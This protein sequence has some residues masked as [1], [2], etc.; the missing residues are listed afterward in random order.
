[1]AWVT[2]A[3][4]KGLGFAN[5]RIVND[6]LVV[7][8]M[9]GN[10][11]QQAGA[12]VGDVRGR[13]GDRG[14]QG[15]QGIQGVK[16]DRGFK[17]LGLANARVEGDL[18][19]IDVMDGDTKTGEL[20]AGNVRGPQGLKGDKGD[21]G[22]TGSASV[23]INDDQTGTE[24]TWSSSKIGATVQTAN[25]TLGQQISTLLAQKAALQHKHTAADLDSGVL[26]P[27]RIPAATASARGGLPIATEGEARAGTVNTKGMTPLTVK[28]AIDALV[29]APPVA[30]ETVAGVS[31]RATPAQVLAGADAARHVVPATLA[32]ALAPIRVDA[33]DAPML[34]HDFAGNTTPPNAVQSGQSLGYLPVGG[35]LSGAGAFTVADGMLDLATPPLGGGAQWGYVEADLGA[36]VQRQGVEFVWDTRNGTLTDPG[37]AALIPWNQPGIVAGGNGQT[38][39]LHLIFYS[40]GTVLAQYRP[41]TGAAMTTMATWS[42]PAMST[43]A[44]S[45]HRVEWWRSGDE[46]IIS[47]DGRDLILKNANLRAGP[48]ESFACW[49]PYPESGRARFRM[50]RIWAD[51][52]RDVPGARRFG[53]RRS[54]ALSKPV[55]RR[56]PGTG[57]EISGTANYVGLPN[58]TLQTSAGDSGRLLVTTRCFIKRGSASGMGR[59]RVA[60]TAD[61]VNWNAGPAVHLSAAADTNGSTHTPTFIVDG[62][63]PLVPVILRVEVSDQ[64]GIT[65]WVMGDPGSARD[66]LITAAPIG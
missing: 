47:V 46:V 41:T 33:G 63:P 27:A 31:Q 36:P 61:T 66:L 32:G 51:G 6:A 20:T 35:N 23:A 8:L 22:D 34:W 60:W 37:M 55:W 25:T 50:R 39:G 65:T 4:L 54:E 43:D 5:P 64:A 52:G 3:D 42:I 38:T 56:V 11:L 9:D 14:I 1:M 7:D 49:E 17:G 57:A 13:Q 18:L 12:V 28:Q 53:Q 59:M 40:S 29:P 45:V 21:K 44:S 10:T 16:G 19:V 2:I 26:D 62:L 58:A 24:T 48:G 15:I 30:S